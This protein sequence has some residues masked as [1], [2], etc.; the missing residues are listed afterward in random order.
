M[1]GKTHRSLQA[2]S[3]LVALTTA[4]C[5]DS[6][7]VSAVAQVEINVP[8][9]PIRIGATAQFSATPR[10]RAGQ[11]IAGRPVTWST[12][13]PAV[14]TI[15]ATGLLTALQG[16]SVSVTATVDGT[17]GSVSIT[18]VVPQPKLEQLS[19]AEADIGRPGLTIFVLGSEFMPG[20]VVRFN[21][22]D[23]ATTFH[24]EARLSAVL[25]AADLAN[26]GLH[27]VVVRN[28]SPGGLESSP[29]L[30]FQVNIKVTGP[31]AA[32]RSTH[33][34]AVNDNGDVFCW[35]RN[36]AGQLG[37]NTTTDRASPIKISNFPKYVAVGV[38]FDFGCALTKWGS[39]D[40]WGANSYGQLGNGTT[41]G[42][43]TPGS[44]VAGPFFTALAV[45]ANF[46]CG[47]DGQGRAWC[48]GANDVGQLGDGTTTQRLTPTAVGGNLSFRAISAG[49]LHACGL[50]VLNELY[51]WGY[52]FFGQLGL[53]DTST[54]PNPVRV[55]TP[56][57]ITMV[58]AG[59]R[60]TC[61]IGQNGT[62]YCWGEGVLGQ[63]GNGQQVLPVTTPTAIP[64]A[65]FVFLVSG[66]DHSCGLTASGAAHCWG[67]NFHGQL[68]TGTLDNS[69]S[70]DAVQGT[71]TF[72]TL[73]AGLRTTCGLTDA[74]T[75]Y[76]W[77][78]R[79]FGEL[80]DDR[81]AYRLGPRRITT[82]YTSVQTGFHFSCGLSGGAPRCWGDNRYGQLGNGTT[83]SAS[84]PVQ[85]SLGTLN[86]E[87]TV[88][89]S[90]ACNRTNAG[91]VTCWGLGQFGRLGNGSTTNRSLP[92][93]ISGAQTYRS[94]SAGYD[95][96]C[97][98]TTAGQV[99]CWGDNGSGELGTGD[100]NDRNVPATVIGV[101]GITFAEVTAGDSHTCART[102][103]GAVYCWGENADGRVGDGTTTDRTQPVP[104]NVGSPVVS[105]STRDRNTC[106]LTANG[107][108]YCWGGN[109]NGSLGTGPGNPTGQLTPAIVQTGLS[110][111]S[112][113]VG[114]LGVCGVA[115]TG[116]GY[117]WGENA[118]GQLGVI[119]LAITRNSPTRINGFGANTTY[120]LIAPGWAHSC[121]VNPSGEL[122]CW[123]FDLAGELGLGYAGSALA[124]VQ[125]PALTVMAR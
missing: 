125:V 5:K 57:P 28:P 17:T 86:A 90:H 46:S 22:Q 58:T 41:T 51:C 108:A 55:T 81:M 18:I 102:T 12:S 50:T 111:V 39:T 73:I 71:T 104:I 53:G 78:S 109:S 98:V 30:G 40:C 106:A 101:A 36:D 20:A 61:A 124:P 29:G 59:A 3:L 8:A 105:V 87:V 96:T 52:N 44:V 19:P 11:A 2:L 79:G 47:L 115:T 94:I 88:G 6:A 80:G 66:S 9:G 56:S 15:D 110:F 123:G 121:G 82:S 117:C 65:S 113:R 99:Q 72:H 1:A 60:H 48:W 70:P 25:T 23:R 64:G 120:T 4:G 74:R 89:H 95:H 69:F 75:M 24:S 92:T 100:V 62:S 77:G 67:N 10:D 27:G 31:F 91:T 97:G 84:S 38:G 63:L 26:P 13:S 68:G 122:G 42:R 7:S 85:L 16:G 32:V 37:D 33:T 116:D 49:N 14:A 114:V 83:T 45:G 103:A 54:R 112:L 76:C 43:P 35:G 119:T 21:G 34:C 118:H 93:L 107:T